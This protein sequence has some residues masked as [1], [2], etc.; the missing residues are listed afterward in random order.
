MTYR[1]DIL[2]QTSLREMF[3]PNWLTESKARRRFFVQKRELW[4]SPRPRLF[5]LLIG[6]N[7]YNSHEIRNL[8]GCVADVLDMQTFLE[9]TLRVPSNRIQILLDEHATRAQILQHIWDLAFNP[10]LD[11]RHGDPILIFYAGHG[12]EFCASGDVNSK[13]QMLLPHDFVPETRVDKD[14]QAILDITLGEMLSDI[15]AAKGNNITVILDT[16]HSGSGTRNRI[17]GSEKVSQNEDLM[18][19][20]VELPPN[21]TVQR[22]M[23]NNPS[24][25]S[26]VRHASRLKNR[27]LASHVLLAACMPNQIAR[28]KSGRGVFTQELLR[29]LRAIGAD[30]FTYKEIIERLPELPMQ[31]PQC[32]GMYNGRTLFNGQVPSTGR[33]LYP[34]YIKEADIVIQAGEAHGIMKGAQFNVFA[35]DDLNP[36]RS[37]NLVVTKTQ[38]FESIAQY[39]TRNS[40]LLPMIPGLKGFWA[41][42]K[43]AGE[44]EAIRV[45]IPLV[46]CFIGLLHHLAV[47]MQEAKPDTMQILLVEEN[48][49]ANLVL[50]VAGETAGQTRMMVSFEPSDSTCQSHGLERMPYMVPLEVTPLYSILAHAAHFYWHLNRSSRRSGLAQYVTVQCTQLGEDPAKPPAYPDKPVFIP[51]GNDLIED[52]EM[53]LELDGRPSVEYGFT[54]TNNSPDPLYVG[55]FY[56]DMSDLSI[57]PLYVPPHAK[58]SNVFPSIPGDGKTLTI[59]Y[60]TGGWPA[61]SFKLP[62]LPNGRL[63]DVDIGFLKL[64]IS[65]KYVDCSEM[66]QQ[67]PFGNFRGIVVRREY[68][69]EVW[70]TIKIPVVL[71]RKAASV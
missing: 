2:H 61:I 54:I 30:K 63:A 25:H 59:G 41:L 38:A 32:E 17:S 10:G 66:E 49:P 55:L 51:L 29:L 46:D 48:E 24:S 12:S 26:G 57:S 62:T 6:I 13:I 36:D 7:K 52:G 22:I 21:Y 8:N 50:H 37:I 33:M 35:D 23:H 27:G 43:S 5:A 44:R 31:N 70:D 64:F 53:N 71:R 56:F 45:R 18:I 68:R 34:V 42:Q 19:R 1:A 28:E 39:A 40:D 65:T 60:G 11:I 9:K 14:S 16:C 3:P 15:S 69:S 4:D 67:S 20:G 58:E 47:K